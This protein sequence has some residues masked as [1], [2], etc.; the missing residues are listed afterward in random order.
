MINVRIHTAVL[1]VGRG[2]WGGIVHCHKQ[3]AKMSLNRT[4]NLFYSLELFRLFFTGPQSRFGEK[5]LR[6]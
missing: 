2:I 6:I 1:V 5:L 4:I 3:L